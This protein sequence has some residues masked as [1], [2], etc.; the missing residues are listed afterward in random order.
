[1]TDHKPNTLIEDA[2]KKALQPTPQRSAD[3]PCDQ[4]ALTDAI[5]GAVDPANFYMRAEHYGNVAGSEET[6][7]AVNEIARNK[8]RAALA[9]IATAGHEIRPPD[10]PCD[11]ADP[12][13]T[14]YDLASERN[15]LDGLWAE[16]KDRLDA[17]LAQV[18]RLREAMAAIVAR[19]E[20]G[21]LGTSRTR[22]MAGL[23]RAALAETS[24][25]E[26]EALSSVIDAVLQDAMASGIG[27]ARI[28]PDEFFARGDRPCTCHP[29]ERPAKCQK[30]Y[31]L[32]D[33]LAALAETADT[34]APAPTDDGWTA[35]EGGECPVAG[36]TMVEV[37]FRSR[38][39]SAVGLARNWDWS[40]GPAPVSYD[41]VA[42]RI[43][44]ARDE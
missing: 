27:I 34:P 23:A 17:A 26:I 41:I 7:A 37:V 32:S 36:G 40:R 24:E 8:A 16:T 3:K 43:A 29:S 42:Y 6:A 31:A 21:E 19:S 28:A 2:F 5:A 22:D 38:I 14:A 33:C 15:T 18:A 35:W 25:R 30:K 20:N 13:S 1:M 44:E 12:C 11:P 4:D 39:S 10:K 9:A